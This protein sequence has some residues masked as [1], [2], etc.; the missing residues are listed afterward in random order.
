M[1]TLNELQQRLAVASE[2]NRT[3]NE[4]RTQVLADIKEKFGCDSVDELRVL[5]EEKGRQAQTLK[6]D[7]EAKRQKAEDA[8]G[9]VEIAVGVRS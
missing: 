2:R 9:A 7:A 4:R 3:N 1:T 5:V 6:D 8:V